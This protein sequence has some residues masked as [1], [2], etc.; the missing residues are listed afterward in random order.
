[1]LKYLALIRQILHGIIHVSCLICNCAKKRKREKAPRKVLMQTATRVLS[2]NLLIA[3]QEANMVLDVANTYCKWLLYTNEI[4]PS[5]DMVLADL[6]EATFGSYARKAFTWS[7]IG[8]GPDGNAQILPEFEEPWTSTDDVE[9]TCYGMALVT[10]LA[11]GGL[12]IKLLIV[13]PFV[14][15]NGDPDPQVV[16]VAGD[17]VVPP[18]PP[19]FFCMH[20]P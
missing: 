20:A 6:V 16:A 8:N 1:M 4:V 3:A 12:G 18:T 9:E 14:D 11:G 15:S 19:L 13:M 10:D 2:K 5:P 7:A 17:Q